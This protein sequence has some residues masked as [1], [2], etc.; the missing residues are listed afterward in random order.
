MRVADVAEHAAVGELTCVAYRDLGIELGDYADVLRDVDGRAASTTVLVAL[1]GEQVVGAVTYVPGPGTPSSEFEDPDAAGIRF[2]AVSP[3]VQRNGI[4]RV[5][6]HACIDRARAD[7]R[8]RLILHTTAPMGA[9]QRLYASEGFRR[10]DER[11]LVVERG[12]RLMAY[13]LDLH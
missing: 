6:L 11:D 8:R 13:E 3:D 7:A 4:G 9:A 2:L 5:L 10:A 1:V 12:I